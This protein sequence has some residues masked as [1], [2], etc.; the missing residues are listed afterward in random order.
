MGDAAG[1]GLD[2]EGRAVVRVRGL[3][4]MGMTGELVAEK[5]G[6]TREVQDAYALESHRRAADAQRG[7]KG[8]LRLR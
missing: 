2:G 3:Q 1:G 5:H 7:T 4:H 6:I 8:G